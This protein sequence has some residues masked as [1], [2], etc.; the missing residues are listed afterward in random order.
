MIDTRRMT[1]EGIATSVHIGGP[2]RTGPAGPGLTEAVVFVHG[3]PDSG[4][5]W[6]PLM[7]RVA[8]YATVV[9]PDLPGFGSAAARPDGDYTIY[10]YARFLHGVIEKLGIQRVHLV[11]HDFGGPFAA[12]WAADHPDRVASVTFVNTGVLVGYRWHRMARIWRTP[13]LGGLSMRLLDPRTT[14]K[15]LARE[16]PGLSREWV[17]VIAGHLLPEKTRRA[18]LRLY[19]STRPGDMDQLAARLREHDHNALVLFGD[20]D[21]YIPVEQAH[22]QAEIFPR[23]IVK[24]LPGLGHWCWLENTD[25]VAGHLEGFLRATLE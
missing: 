18:V 21:A 5:D 16:N 15:V 19:R 25:V 3:N 9:A 24:I 17:Q 2:G 13:V 10:S 6:M 7:T 12:A 8:R 23:A 22:R 14:A 11:A 1:V 20:A 4:S